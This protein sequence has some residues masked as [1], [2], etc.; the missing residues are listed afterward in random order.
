MARVETSI[1]LSQIARYCLLVLPLILLP[2]PAAGIIADTL[3]I[4]NIKKKPGYE[5][6]HCYFLLGLLIVKDVC[7]LVFN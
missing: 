3:D 2:E 1:G 7:Q 5:P 4:I 6:G